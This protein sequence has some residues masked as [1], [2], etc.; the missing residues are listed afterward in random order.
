M[1]I[2]IIGGTQFVGRHMA[3]VAVSRGHDVTLFHRGKTGADLFPGCEHILGDRDHDLA[4]LADGVWDATIDACAYVPRQVTE[5]LDA[6][7]DRAGLFTFVS[8]VSVYAEPFPTNGDESSPLATLDDPTTEVVTGETYGGLKVL[9]EEVVT[10]R[11]GEN[12]L[13]IRPTYVVGPYDH[14]RRFTYWVERIADGGE[15][16]APAPPDVSNTG[17]RCPR[18]SVVGHRHD[19][20][21]GDRYLPHR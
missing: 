7:G 3:E 21:T 12:A 4:R 8:T 11:L 13:V 2:L 1:R 15:V 16:L 17:H 14:T 19:R 20:T 10:G 5:L 6:L 9:C 18:P